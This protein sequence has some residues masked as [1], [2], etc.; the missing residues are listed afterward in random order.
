MDRQEFDRNYDEMTGYF[1]DLGFNH[2]CF[3]A[4]S[5]ST[6]L[7]KETW[8]NEEGIFVEMDPEQRAFTLS[9]V[10][11]MIEC[12]IK[13]LGFPNR[14]TPMFIKKLRRHLPVD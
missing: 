10:D 11:G 14:H 5:A 9:V 6:G 8:S 13:N 3:R 4:K 7:F 12:A 2:V 1:R